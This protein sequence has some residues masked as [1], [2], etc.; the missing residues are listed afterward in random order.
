MFRG[1]LLLRGKNRQLNSTTSDPSHRKIIERKTWSI[2]KNICSLK[3]QNRPG[4][5]VFRLNEYL[6]VVEDN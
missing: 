4:W 5:L 3:Q 2:K 1:F 6:V